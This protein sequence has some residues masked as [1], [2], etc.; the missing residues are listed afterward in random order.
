MIFGEEGNDRPP[1]KFTYARRKKGEVTVT[2][3]G[4]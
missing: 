4:R 3:E 1:I 2:K